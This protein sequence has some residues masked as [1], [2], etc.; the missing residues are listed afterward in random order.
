[1]W[2][3]GQAA[4]KKSAVLDLSKHVDQRVRVK[5][6][7][8]REGE[9]LRAC[10]IFARGL[11]AQAQQGASCAQ[12][13]AGVRGGGAVGPQV[14]RCSL[15]KAQAS[16]EERALSICKTCMRSESMTMSGR[17][18]GGEWA[19]VCMGGGRLYC[20]K[21]SDR[22]LSSRGGGGDWAWC[23]VLKESG[24]REFT[25]NEYSI[26]VMKIRGANCVH[27]CAFCL[28]CLPG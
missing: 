25:R 5:F 11:S 7:G 24:Q 8:G 26:T 4:E 3:R 16:S 17:A 27:A 20:S 12:L 14:W 6:T 21:K 18:G 10:P 9:S 19:L 15:G 28:T 13:C 2:A 1:V 23:G 22:K